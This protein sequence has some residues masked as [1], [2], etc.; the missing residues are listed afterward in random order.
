VAPIPFPNHN[1]DHLQRAGIVRTPIEIEP[2]AGCPGLYHSGRILGLCSAQCAR[3][4]GKELVPAATVVLGHASCVNHLELELG[5]DHAATVSVDASVSSGG[6]GVGALGKHAEMVHGST[7]DRHPAE[8][9]SPNAT[10]L[11]NSRPGDEI[12][13]GVTGVRGSRP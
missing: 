13:E 2:G 6:D 5:Y 12:V 1:L 4:G 7:S 11:T 3:M 8:L 9:G 10:F